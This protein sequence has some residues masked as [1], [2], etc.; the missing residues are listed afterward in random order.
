MDIAELQRHAAHL[1]QVWEF[2]I[3][4]ESLPP[5]RQWG[6]W[7]EWNPP[8]RIEEAIKSLAKRLQKGTPLRGEDAPYRYVTAALKGIRTKAGEQ[9]R[10]WKPSPS[11]TLSTVPPRE[12]AYTERMSDEAEAPAVWH[13]A[14]KKSNWDEARER[15]EEYQRQRDSLK[16][17]Q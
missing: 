6:R 1:S 5:N 3:D 2:Y 15:A 10:A 17:P 7:L 12:P 11:S 14:P 9:P 8:E 13:V 16:E 4:K